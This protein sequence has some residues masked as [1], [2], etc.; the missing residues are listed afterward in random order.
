MAKY[1]IIYQFIGYANGLAEYSGT[2]KEHDWKVG[3]K[4]IWGRGI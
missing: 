2:W 4:E 3:D 1:V